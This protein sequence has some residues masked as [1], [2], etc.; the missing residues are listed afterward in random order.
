MCFWG[1]AGAMQSRAWI[2][3]GE[4]GADKGTWLYSAYLDSHTRKD[5]QEGRWPRQMKFKGDLDLY[6]KFTNQFHLFIIN[7]DFLF[8]IKDVTS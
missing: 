3:K 4:A 7:Y 1:R 2:A 6:S 5:V 8:K